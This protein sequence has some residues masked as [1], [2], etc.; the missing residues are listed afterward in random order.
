M[1]NFREMVLEAITS[2]GTL[3]DLSNKNVL[4]D[5]FDAISGKYPSFTTYIPNIQ[6]DTFHSIAWNNVGTRPTVSMFVNNEIYQE[7][8][9]YLDFL[10]SIRDKENLKM[11]EWGSDKF[12]AN[13]LGPIEDFFIK[14]IENMAVS[15]NPL[16]GYTPM[17]SILSARHRQI[18]D[19]ILSNG[20]V[21]AKTIKNCEKK[22]YTIRQAIYLATQLRQRNMPIIATI[23]TN[24][25][26]IDDFLIQSVIDENAYL[27]GAVKPSSAGRDIKAVIKNK[28]SVIFRPKTIPTAVKDMVEVLL[29]FMDSVRSYAIIKDTIKFADPDNLIVKEIEE[30]KN[31]VNNKLNSKVTDIV[32]DPLNEAKEVTS[33][34]TSL[35]NHIPG[36]KDIVGKLQATAGALGDAAKAFGA[37]M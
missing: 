21:G 2:E 17:S 18:K 29:S 27:G 37:R 4:K 32:K 24:N 28:I 11:K 36:E 7:V 26:A 12:T 34:L 6:K 14:H 5:L 31:S 1:I 10:C 9:P 23:P 15:N 35:L 30:L 20:L 25:K 13:E 16:F 19:K 22:Q 3:H 8:Y 33:K